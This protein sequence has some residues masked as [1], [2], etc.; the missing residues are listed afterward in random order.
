MKLFL[1]QKIKSALVLLGPSV[2]ICVLLFTDLIRGFITFLP[3]APT[4]SKRTNPKNGALACFQQPG[5]SKVCNSYCQ[6]GY[7]FS[8]KPEGV[9]ICYQEKWQ[10]YRGHFQILMTE[11]ENWPDCAGECLNFDT[12]TK[13]NYL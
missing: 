8:Y 2:I 4:C 11:H 12:K 10:Y 13:L 5:G 3:L 1:L 9:Y 7:D 6:E